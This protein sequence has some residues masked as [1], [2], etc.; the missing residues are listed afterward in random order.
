[1]LS[2]FVENAHNLASLRFASLRWAQLVDEEAKVVKLET[3]EQEEREKREKK[4]ADKE[5][6]KAKKLQEVADKKAAQVARTLLQQEQKVLLNSA[7]TAEKTAEAAKKAE[8]K[9]EKE[10]RAQLL[11]EEKLSKQLEIKT[12]KDVKEAQ[13]NKEKEKKEKSLKKQSGM[14]LNFFGVKKEK[15][16]EKEGGE[17]AEG[18]EKEKGE[19]KGKDKVKEMEILPTPKS[20]LSKYVDQTKAD[21][22]N[23]FNRFSDKP[24]ATNDEDCSS[25][26]W[27]SIDSLATHNNNNNSSSNNSNSNNSKSKLVSLNVMQTVFTG[28][29]FNQRAYSEVSERSGAERSE[30]S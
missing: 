3:A 25:N 6:D 27:S 24:T 8:E 19:E 30:L 14:M 22:D 26:H 16:K 1:M 15:E 10:E 5:M 4:E 12:K 18:E 29:G 17:K 9:K 20:T 23:R 28:S 2:C 13:I 21:G 11:K 7:K